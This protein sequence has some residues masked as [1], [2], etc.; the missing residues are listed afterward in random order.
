M[1]VVFDE[2]QDILNLKDASTTLAVLRSKIQFHTDIPYI[3]AGSI[4][5]RMDEIFNNPD[6]PFFKS[7]ITINVGPLDREVFSGFLQAKFSKG[8]RRVS[9][10]LLDRV[11]EITQDNPGDIQ[12]LCGAVW[13]VTSYN[14]NIKEDIIPSA[15]EL[16]FSRELKGYEAILSQ[17]T[18]QQ[19]RCLKGLARLGG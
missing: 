8:K 13:E 14:D 9:Q 15:L 19:L 17:V 4:R 2:F 10:T 12:Q 16:V 11:F 18:G 1:A 6:S 7:A 5:N 3:F